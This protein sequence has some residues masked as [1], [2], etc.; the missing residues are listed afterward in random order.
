MGL[1]LQLPCSVVCQGMSSATSPPQ[2][3]GLSCYEPSPGSWNVSRKHIP[4]SGM[5]RFICWHPD[6][7]VWNSNLFK[8]IVLKKI[9]ALVPIR[10]HFEMLKN[11]KQVNLSKA[12]ELGWNSYTQTKQKVREAQITRLSLTPVSY[13]GSCSTLKAAETGATEAAVRCRP[14]YQTGV[15]L[16]GHF[17]WH[18][19]S[20]TRISTH[21]K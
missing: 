12:K 17:L 18:H 21:I 9:G 11:A 6:G 8:S 3:F 2:T 15:R 4:A 16:K 14:P 1:F 13:Q 20:M 19:L 5:P 10:L 7:F